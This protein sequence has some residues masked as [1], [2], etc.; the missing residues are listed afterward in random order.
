MFLFC[1]CVLVFELRCIL[2]FGY[3]SG[4]IV[5]VNAETVTVKVDLV[6]EPEVVVRF[7]STER[8]C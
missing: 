2:W 6:E 5:R 1:Y 4:T 7:V 3:F 8:C